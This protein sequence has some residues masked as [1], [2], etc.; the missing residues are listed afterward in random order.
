MD[1][2]LKIRICRAV[3]LM[4]LAF[5]EDP[6]GGALAGRE[7]D[8]CD[9]LTGT[10]ERGRRLRGHGLGRLGW[11]RGTPAKYKFWDYLHILQLI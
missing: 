11:R 8:G 6:D 3:V 2:T 1:R 10:E 9:L 4:C 5:D 7:G